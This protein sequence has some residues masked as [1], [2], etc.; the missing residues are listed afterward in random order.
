MVPDKEGA[1]KG[2]YE[3]HDSLYRPENYT[4]WIRPS[5]LWTL[6]IMLLFATMQC[7]NVLMRQGW[8]DREKLPFPV[9][10]IPMQ[11][12]EPSARLWKSSLFWIGFTI[13]AI[14]D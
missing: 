6:F 14:M 4:A 11:M 8:Q 5:L 3:G 7:L 10:E 1:L 9:I 2:Y 13:V 12:T